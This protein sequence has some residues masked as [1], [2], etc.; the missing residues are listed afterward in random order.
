VFTRHLFTNRWLWASFGVVVVLQVLV[1][2]VAALA[3]IFDTTA[4]TLV[5][6]LTCLAVASS[7]LW[8]DEAAKL[9]AR[10]RVSES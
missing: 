8:V 5:Q 3:A 9:V 4:L 2:Q 1:V 7:V 6:W 10:Q